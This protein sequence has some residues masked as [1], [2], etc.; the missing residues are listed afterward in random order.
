MLCQFLY[1]EY[2][3]PN[4]FTLNLNNLI[5]KGVSTLGPKILSRA[6]QQDMHQDILK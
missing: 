5:P 3:N 4:I 6:R 2:I 1:T